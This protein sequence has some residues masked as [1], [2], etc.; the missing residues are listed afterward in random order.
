MSDT[1]KNKIKE[2]Y[3]QALT[4]RCCG[5]GGADQHTVENGGTF[6]ED[7]QRLDGYVADADYGLGCGLPTEVAR[8]AEG[9]TVLDLGSGAGNDVF[10]ARRVVGETG[11]V[12]GVD[13][14]EAMVARAEEN[15]QKLG[16]PN[17]EFILG[18][19]EA[20]PLPDASVDV[21][22]SNCVMNLV[23]DKTQAY[24]EVYRVLKPGGHFSISDIVVQGTLPPAVRAAAELYAG[25]VAGAVEKNG[26]LDLIRAAGFPD[27]E[28]LREAPHHLPDDLLRKYLSAEELADFRRSGSGVV[29]VTLNATKS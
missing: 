1:I 17:V 5:G 16:Y 21:V 27:V 2:T 6:A 14:T 28:V 10:V 29:S 7:Y 25:C 3:T 4:Q 13:M 12:I 24:A 20:L 15:R 18:E 22:V 19:I 26:Y 23:P 8:L 9:Q 11:R